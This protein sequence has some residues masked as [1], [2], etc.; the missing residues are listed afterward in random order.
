MTLS[1][2]AEVFLPRIEADEV[3]D[4]M[5]EASFGN[6]LVKLTHVPCLLRQE[7][8]RFR[9]VVGDGGDA[10]FSQHGVRFVRL[11]EELH[12]G[13]VERNVERG[14]RL[15]ELLHLGSADDRRRHARFVQ[16]PGKSDLRRRHGAALRQLND[17]VDDIEVESV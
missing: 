5:I 13:R 1:S 12:L 14:E 11:L 7:Q 3:A 4:T 10:G 16:D 9:E 2:G 15:L 6:D 8:N 17:P